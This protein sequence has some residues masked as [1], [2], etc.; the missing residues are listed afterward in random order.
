MMSDEDE[1]HLMQLSSVVALS[2]KILYD[3][4]KAVRRRNAT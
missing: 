3:I 2:N 4:K 1:M